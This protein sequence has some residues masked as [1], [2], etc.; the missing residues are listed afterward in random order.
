MKKEIE[1]LDKIKKNEK[2][3]YSCETPEYVVTLANTNGMEY[4]PGNIVYYNNNPE[5]PQQMFFGNIQQPQDWTPIAMTPGLMAPA[6]GQMQAQ[7]NTGAWAQQA[8]MDEQRAMQFNQ[9]AMA[10]PQFQGFFVDEPL[11]EHMPDGTVR[12][13]R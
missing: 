11:Y 9:Q 12:R 5:P 10:M 8:N 7:Q 2:L 6:Q 13:V 3:F 4:A 1:F